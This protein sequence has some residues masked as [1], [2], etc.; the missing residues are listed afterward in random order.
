MNPFHTIDPNLTKPDGLVLQILLENV[1]TLRARSTL[2][3]ESNNDDG[4]CSQSSEDKIP[5]AKQSP[6]QGELD[7]RSGRDFQS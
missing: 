2:E 1:Q 5:D 3:L 6:D 4:Y 7:F